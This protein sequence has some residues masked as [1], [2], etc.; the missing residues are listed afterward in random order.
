MQEVKPAATTDPTTVRLS[1]NLTQE[2]AEAL[3]SIARR[4]GITLTE[5][6]RR[7]ISTQKFIE[8]AL[9]GKAKIL[10]VEPD[11]APRELVFLR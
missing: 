9:D 3:K 10:I 11:Q 4:H 2:V 6:I 1:V 8:D 7:A 5:A